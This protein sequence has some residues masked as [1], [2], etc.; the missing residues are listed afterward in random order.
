M[1]LA[2]KI[3]PCSYYIYIEGVKKLKSIRAKAKHWTAKKL[4][5]LKEEAK[6]TWPIEGV[7]YLLFG[8]FVFILTHNALVFFNQHYLM[9]YNQTPSLPGHFFL[10]EKDKRNHLKRGDYVS[11]YTRDLMPYYPKGSRFVKKIVGIGRDFIS[12]NGRVFTIC[13]KEN[14]GQC[15][16]TEALKTDSKGNPAPRFI[17]EG[18]EIP[19]DCYFV[20]GD[21][22]R[23]FDSRYWGYVCGE[24]V[25]GKAVKVF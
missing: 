2:P 16:K 20:L 23:S 12:R 1:P 3:Y 24:E 15:I 22:P 25:I 6:N 19:L 21:H 18:R 9:G 11:F 10:V 17:P 7:I 13:K 5:L 14:P 4:Y 8:V